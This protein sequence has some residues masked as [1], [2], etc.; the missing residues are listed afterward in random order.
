MSDYEFTEDEKK[1]V[2]GCSEYGRA[3]AG[4]VASILLP[5]L[6]DL[7]RGKA[8]WERIARLAHGLKERYY[9]RTRN[10]EFRSELMENFRKDT[11]RIQDYL[12]EHN[13]KGGGRLVDIILD[14]IRALETDL[15]LEK[16]VSESALKAM[17]AAERRE[18]YY[19]V[20]SQSKPRV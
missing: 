19:R 7:E 1:M 14:K 18:S 5:K 2:N 13:I 10:A 6:H 16:Q 20:K 11:V 9:I 15:K 4:Y 12:D 8:Q 17:R 3:G